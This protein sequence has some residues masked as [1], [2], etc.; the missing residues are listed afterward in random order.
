[1]ERGALLGRQQ[2][3][4]L[5]A[6]VCLASTPDRWRSVSEIASSQAL[7][8]AMLEQLLL[9]LRRGGLVEARRGR[10]G[11]YRLR[12]SPAA[13]NLTMVLEALTPTPSPG[14]QRSLVDT[15]S[16]SVGATAC[17]TADSTDPGP[18][19]QAPLER[20][21]SE[22]VAEALE[23]RLQR[24]LTRELSRISLEDLLFD[25]R[26]SEASLEDDGGLMLP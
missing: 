14:S 13:I 19:A 8:A 15:D 9:R 1:M 25:L 6:L 22:R 11:G 2:I 16:E 20:A 3:H 12:G 17:A 26:S 23:Q 24:A 7:P 5:R 21:A 18:G 10:L 4:A